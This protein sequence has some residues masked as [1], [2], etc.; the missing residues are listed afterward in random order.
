MPENFDCIRIS[1]VIPTRNRARSL[2]ACIDSIACQSYP[3]AEI[4]VVDDGSSDNTE[5]VVAEY[6]NMRVRYARLE[7]GQGAQAA[8]NH[9]VALARHDWIAFQDSDDLW[10]PNKLQAQVNALCESGFGRFAVVHSDGR[11]RD[12]SSGS[13]EDIRIPH[14]AGKCHRQLLLQAGPMF[15]SLLV[16]KWALL[17]AGGLDDQCPSYQ[18]W[19]TAIRLSRI[20]SFVHVRQ[21]LFI[22]NWH[23]G[24]T[25]SKDFSRDLRGFDYV[26]LQH[27]EEIIATHGITAWRR[28]KIY[29]VARALSARHWSDAEAMMADETHHRSIAMARLFARYR[30]FPP[31]GRLLLLFLSTTN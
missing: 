9:G 11:R 8:R 22:W 18:E 3:A 12:E 25:I 6:D 13:E 31:K 4:I 2:P 29:N 1:I 30:F 16:P 14:T 10:L 26:I 27:R 19:D 7:G 20:C 15:P 21:P 28:L 23:G 17:E 5:Q 24:D